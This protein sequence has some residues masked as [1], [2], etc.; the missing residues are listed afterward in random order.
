MDAS[1]LYS[2]KQHRYFIP[3]GCSRFKL[4]KFPYRCFAIFA[5]LGWAEQRHQ[6]HYGLSTF[7]KL[8]KFASATL[9]AFSLGHAYEL[10]AKRHDSKMQDVARQ[11]C[12]SFESEG[13]IAFEGEHKCAHLSSCC[14]MGC[15][16]TDCVWWFLFV[17]MAFHLS[18]WGAQV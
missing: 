18:E 6:V 14:S 5:R 1:G 3:M 15:F 12:Y 4:M 8:V 2:Q 11:F 10:V 9:Q 7:L 16:N 13:H 17:R